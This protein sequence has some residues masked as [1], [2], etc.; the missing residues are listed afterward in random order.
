M[1]ARFGGREGALWHE[2]LR[3][4]RLCR[5]VLTAPASRLV[6]PRAPPMTGPALAFRA[7]PP[8]GRAWPTPPPPEADAKDASLKDAADKKKTGAGKPQVFVLPMEG[9]DPIRVTDSVE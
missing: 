4:R 6:A 3:C 7:G 2:D 1:V 9:G 8:T 5:R